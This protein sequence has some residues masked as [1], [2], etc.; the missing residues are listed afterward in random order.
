[1]VFAN[2]NLVSSHLD[3]N[4]GG[5]FH[6]T[7]GYICAAHSGRFFAELGIHSGIFF[8]DFGIHSGVIFGNLGILSGSIFVTGILLGRILIEASFRLILCYEYS[9]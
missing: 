9:L 1:M 7:G 2:F 5:F 3:P 6:G 4:P 8:T